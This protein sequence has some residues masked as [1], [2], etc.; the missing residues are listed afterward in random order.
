MPAKKSALKNAFP[1][2]LLT[3]VVTVCV[4]LL[5]YVDSLTRERISAQEDEAVKAMLDEM[6]PDMSRY[7]FQNEIYIIYSDGEQ[8]GYAFLAV[9]KGYG[10][11]INILVGLNDDTTLKGITIVSQ[12]ETPGLGTRITEPSFT[13]QFAGLDVNQV[14][15]SR[16]GGRIDAITGSTIS[17]SAVVE[18]VRETALEKIKQI[19]EEK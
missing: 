16:D 8:I 18:A 19:E 15:L 14:A 17:S 6:F 13:D 1:V 4:S 10:G 9:G 12:E 5:T 3:V 11:D 2:I 7:D